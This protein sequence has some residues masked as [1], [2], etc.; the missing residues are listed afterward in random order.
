M[1]SFLTDCLVY[2]DHFAGFY[3]QLL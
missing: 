3:S 2:L 1:G